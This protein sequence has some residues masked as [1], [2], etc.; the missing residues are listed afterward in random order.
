MVLGEARQAE[1]R[2]LWVGVF[3][4]TGATSP[5]QGSI[6]RHFSCLLYTVLQQQCCRQWGLLDQAC[7]AS[8]SLSQSRDVQ[9]T[10]RERVGCS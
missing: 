7:A 6:W 8:R 9:S 2:T 3:V 4:L 1:R 5:W 10:L